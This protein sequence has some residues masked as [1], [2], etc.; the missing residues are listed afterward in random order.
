MKDQGYTTCIAKR[1]STWQHIVKICLNGTLMMD[2]Q[3]RQS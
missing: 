2:L 1:S 3:R